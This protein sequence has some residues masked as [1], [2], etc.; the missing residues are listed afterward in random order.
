MF[1]GDLPGA[2]KLLEESLRTFE[3]VRVDTWG[4]GNA[5]ALLASLSFQGGDPVEARRGILTAID[6]W[7]EQGNA[8]VIASQLRFLAILA[9]AM[10]QPE[11]A[12]R[13]AGA[14]ASLREKV[15]GDTPDAFFPFPEPR[16]T[17]AE[18]LDEETLERAWA[19]GQAMSLEEAL[20]YAREEW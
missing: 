5:V 2:R 6:T 18:A 9:N 1:G 10:G 8:L 15:G 20:A 14:F 7:G 3:E 16:E 13:L 11:R 4:L 17:A 19:E 12:A